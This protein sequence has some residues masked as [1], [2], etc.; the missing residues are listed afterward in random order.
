[1]SL[2]LDMSIKT[3][4]YNATEGLYCMV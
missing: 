4:K 3:N 2:K 1:M